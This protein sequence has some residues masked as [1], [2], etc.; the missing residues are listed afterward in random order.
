M[1]L[2]NWLVTFLWMCIPVGA[3]A[4]YFT[5]ECPYCSE[6]GYRQAAVNAVPWPP[7]GDV[8]VIDYPQATLKAYTV[9]REDGPD[10]LYVGAF[11]TAVPAEIQA[12]FDVVIDFIQ[13]AES[14][15]LGYELPP[16]LGIPTAFDVVNNGR[17]TLI[18]SDWLN[19][20]SAIS[21]QVQGVVDALRGILGNHNP[22]VNVVVE[23]VMPDGSVV[24]MKAE[25]KILTTPNEPEFVVTFE[26]TSALDADGNPIQFSNLD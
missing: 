4:E 26:V 5:I 11:E 2:R 23:V 3:S 25:S 19:Q 22:N 9:F 24:E 21:S 16:E 8:L 7:G 1:S 14:S 13:W 10:G 6:A 20:Q 15:V 18:I 17:N 12:D